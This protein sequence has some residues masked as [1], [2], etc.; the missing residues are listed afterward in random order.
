MTPTEPTTP[1]EAERVALGLRLAEAFE[2]GDL[3]DD[4]GVYLGPDD[5]DLED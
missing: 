1:T 5:Y 2:A 4:P 3:D